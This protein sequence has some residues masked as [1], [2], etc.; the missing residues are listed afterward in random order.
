MFDTLNQYL[1][2]KPGDTFAEIGASSG[3]YDGAMAVYLDNVTFYLQDID[4]ACL[5]E[6]NLDKLLKYYSKFRETPIR[7]TNKFYISI[8]TDTHTNLP[9]NSIDVI[10]SNATYHVLAYPDSILADLHKSLKADGTISIRDQFNLTDEVKYCS[11]KSCGHPLA[12]KEEFMTSM[13]RSGFVL[14]DETDQFGYPV[15]KFRKAADNPSD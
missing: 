6:K 7:Q 14:I 4:E 15:Y 5:N 1:D 13:T 3:Y 2:I 10:Y 11:D 9:E 8:G 12:T